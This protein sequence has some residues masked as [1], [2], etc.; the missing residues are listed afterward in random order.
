[1]DPSRIAALLEP[2]L[3]APLALAQLDQ[4]STYINLL[5]HWNARLNLTAIR[6]P[7]QIIPRHFG[8]SFFLARHL[9]PAH[10]QLE[11]AP[12]FASSAKGGDTT[13]ESTPETRVPAR[14]INSGETTA[15]ARVIDLGSG[16][17]FPAL[18]IKI[19][20]PE[21]HLTLIESNHKKAAFLREVVR[22]LTLTNVDVIPERAEAVAPRLPHPGHSEK[23]E[24]ALPRHQ[25]SQPPLADVVTF[26]AIEKF[27]KI[28]PLAASFLAAH[29]R[30]ALLIGSAQEPR[31]STVPNLRWKTKPVPQSRERVLAIGFEY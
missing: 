11:P 28:L 21:I 24:S 27:D 22:S 20:A 7:E 14:A 19:W 16:A 5:L 15:P 4:I 23:E 31:L 1:M 25:A 13:T 9:F 2:F 3:R 8:E 6:D 30:L 18:P 17:G 26:R 12:P 29:G 10:E